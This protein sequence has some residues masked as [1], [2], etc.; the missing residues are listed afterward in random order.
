M[1]AF[2]GLLMCSLR[3]LDSAAAA[4][5]ARIDSCKFEVEFTE[6][7][8]LGGEDTALERGELGVSALDGELSRSA[9]AGLII[10][11]LG[12]Q[13]Y[14]L[15]F[16]GLLYIDLEGGWGWFTTLQAMHG[17]SQYLH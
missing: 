13:L 17:Q 1:N 9:G 12:T 6:A 4:A 3:D 14:Q 11:E 10:V 8:V 16:G 5:A 7:G 15:R 2:I